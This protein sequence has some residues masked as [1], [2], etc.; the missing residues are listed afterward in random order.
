[1]PMPAEYHENHGNHE[2]ANF[3]LGATQDASNMTANMYRVGGKVTAHTFRRLMATRRVSSAA[4]IN[5]E[6][7]MFAN[8]DRDGVPPV[9]TVLP[10]LGPSTLFL[11]SSGSPFCFPA[12]LLSFFLR[13][14]L[15]VLYVCCFPSIP[16]FPTLALRP[17]HANFLHDESDD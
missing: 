15:Y 4:L 16:S 9:S 13:G 1:M 12:L 7:L 8:G 10:A 11:S 2:N 6:K 14:V 17:G 3:A 5:P